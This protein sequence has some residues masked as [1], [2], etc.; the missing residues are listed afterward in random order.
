VAVSEDAVPTVRERMRS[1]MSD[2]RIEAHHKAGSIRLDGEPVTDLDA[3]APPGT[4]ILIM[5]A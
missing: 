4:R 2:E 5:G 1:T 3:P